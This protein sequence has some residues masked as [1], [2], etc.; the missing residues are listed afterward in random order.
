MQPAADFKR[1]LAVLIDYKVEFIVVG[2][3]SAVLQGAPITTFDLD[4][5][6]KRTTENIEALLKALLSLHSVYRGQ[7]GRTIEPTASALIGEGHNLLISDAGPIDVLGTIGKR[8]SY[9]DLL[10]FT[11]VIKALGSSNVKLLSL[12]KNIDIKEQLGSEKDKAVLPILR[13]TLQE[14]KGNP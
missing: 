4:I 9:E 14:E 1:L 5:V 10:P 13:R 3:V 7:F 2:G 12:A 6:P 8:L 11:I